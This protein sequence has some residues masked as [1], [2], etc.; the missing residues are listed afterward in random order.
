[1]LHILIFD[2]CLLGEI[3]HVLALILG[4][5][6]HELL[7]FFWEGTFFLGGGVIFLVLQDP[8]IRVFWG[9]FGFLS[10]SNA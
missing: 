1:M 2:S 4:S 3:F 5:S 8:T 7:V 9:E 6:G 10:T